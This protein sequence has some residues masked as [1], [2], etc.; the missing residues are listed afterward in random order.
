MLWFGRYSG[1]LYVAYAPFVVVG[2]LMAASIPVVGFNAIRQSEHFA[3]FVVFG[4]LNVVAAVD[5]LKRMLP[6]ALFRAAR[7]LLL[8]AALACLGAVVA[9]FILSALASPTFG[10]SGRSLTLLDPTYASK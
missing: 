10:L 6:E 4:I 3:S 1:R 7:N 9:L 8:S 2:T 5:A